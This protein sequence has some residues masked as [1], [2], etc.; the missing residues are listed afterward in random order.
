MSICYQHIS[1]S[2]HYWA[3]VDVFLT[4]QRER[5]GRTCKRQQSTS[6][7][8][9]EHDRPTLGPVRS[10]LHAMTVVFFLYLITGWISVMN[11]AKKKYRPRNDELFDPYVVASVVEVSISL[12]FTHTHTHAHTHTHTYT[13]T[14]THTHTCANT[15]R[16]QI[17]RAHTHTNLPHFRN[18]GQSRTVLT[19]LPQG[20]PQSCW[21]QSCQ[22][23]AKGIRGKKSLFFFFFKWH[24]DS[25]TGTKDKNWWPLYTK[26]NNYLLVKLTFSRFWGKIMFFGVVTIFA[27]TVIK[28]FSVSPH[29]LQAPVPWTYNLHRMDGQC[30]TLARPGYLTNSKPRFPEFLLPPL[31][32]LVTS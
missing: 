23:C 8:A 6:Q 31:V 30:S 28:C 22:C 14:H 18:V 21:P 7:A 19:C 29:S 17:K 26:F 10:I 2:S 4:R 25:L 15:Y 5:K 32:F 27:D 9:C 1:Y 12:P 24:M 11:A 3:W 13:H 16:F 20:W